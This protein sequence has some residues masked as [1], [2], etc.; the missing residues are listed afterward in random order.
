MSY[1][2]FIYLNS[3]YSDYN[4]SFIQF[5]TQLTYKNYGYQHTLWYNKVNTLV[6]MVA[7]IGNML[8][9]CINRLKEQ[10]LV[11]QKLMIS[12]GEI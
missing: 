3:S 7:T 11:I 4:R 5:L 8:Y 2:I 10:Q 9:K 12:W 6:I 1:L